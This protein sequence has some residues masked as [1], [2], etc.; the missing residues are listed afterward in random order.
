[1]IIE[2][3]VGLILKVNDNT[4]I[5]VSPILFSKDETYLYTWNTNDNTFSFK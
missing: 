5:N 1:M 2:F 4:N 3:T